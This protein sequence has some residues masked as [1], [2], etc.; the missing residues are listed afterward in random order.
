MARDLEHAVVSLVCDILDASALATPAWLIR[1]G[2]AECG[3]RWPLVQTIYHD[4]T[5]LEL[6]EAM[7]PVE[8]R[9][10]DAVL[11][12][13]GEAPR[14]LEVD[15]RQ[16]FNEYRASTLRRYPPELPLAFD[17]DVWL[18]RGEEK[19]RLEGGGFA[20]PKPPLFPGQG[21]RH[22]QR[23]YRDALCDILPAEHGYLPTLRIA[24]FELEG[25][26]GAESARLKMTELMTHKLERG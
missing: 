10:V 11:Q 4:L 6:P 23:A 25:W 15:E 19:T 24:H 3:S 7:R 17:R 1:P 8:R 18:R 16:H 20:A 2:R 12:R 26:I 22:R 14:I 21:G 9:T 13:H 5:G